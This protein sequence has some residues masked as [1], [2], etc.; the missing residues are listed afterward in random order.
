[1]NFWVL[2]GINNPGFSGG[3]VVFLTGPAQKILGVVSGYYN[4]PTDV[5]TAALPNKPASPTKP[6][7]SQPSATKEQPKSNKPPAKKPKQIVNANSGFM[8]AFDITYATEAI[9]KNPIGP[10]RMTPASK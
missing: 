6:D 7:S 9:K 1:M 8:I 5:V 3:P 10:L 4:E 2:D